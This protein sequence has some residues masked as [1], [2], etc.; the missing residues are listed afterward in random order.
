[1]YTPVKEIHQL[2]LQYPKIYSDTRKAVKNSIFIALSSNTT[3][4]GNQ[5]AE[6]AIFEIGCA[7][8]IIDDEDLKKKHKEDKRFLLVKNTCEALK[9]LG[10]IHRQHLNIPILAVAGSNGKT[11]TRKLISAVLSQKYNIG[12]T[13]GNLNNHFGVPLS[14]LNLNE[15]HEIGVIEVGANHLKETKDLCEICIPNFGIVT[16]CG[17]DHLEGYGTL[18]NVI[19]SNAELYDWLAENKGTAF[20]NA[21][22][23]VLLA[24]SGNILN[25]IFYGTATNKSIKVTGEVIKSPWLLCK[26]SINQT[27]QPVKIQIQSKLFGKFWLP[28][29]LAAISIGNHFGIPINLIKKAIESYDPSGMMRSEQIN[30]NGSDVLLD[31]YNAN[32]SSMEVFID[33]I[34]E[35]NTTKKKIFI[36]GSMLEGGLTSVDEHFKILEKLKNQP[37]ES[38][39]LVGNVNNNDFEQAIEKFNHKTPFIYFK[40]A[41]E[42]KEHL[43]KN[44]DTNNYYFVKGSRGIRLESLFDY[45]K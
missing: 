35:F 38:V 10:K 4:I 42:A 5:F 37:E 7:Y 43:L 22:D 26:V 1:M 19:K 20:I 18:E 24:N 27:E 29:I 28:S 25:R 41:A 32:P 9:Q 39:C 6:K 8:T 12:E 21:D 44:Q 31:C 40:N 17:K 11:T 34:L 3:N 2:F 36:L 14:L 30:W 13:Q 23:A 16:N 45:A 15:K 33:E